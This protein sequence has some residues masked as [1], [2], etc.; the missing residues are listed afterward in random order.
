MVGVAMGRRSGYRF[1]KDL[2]RSPKGMVDNG[3]GKGV[4]YGSFGILPPTQR[5]TQ[6]TEEL[7][8]DAVR[9]VFHNVPGA[10][11]PAE[12]AFSVPDRK[13]YGGAENLAQTLHN[14]LPVRGAKVRDS[15]RWSQYTEQALAQTADTEVYFGQHNGPIWGNAR[16]RQFI[17][18]QRD[19]CKYTHDQ[20]VRLANAGLTPREIADTVKLPKT[21]ESIFGVRGYCGDLR[22]NGK[23]VHQLHLGAH[24]GNPANLNPLPPQEAAKRWCCRT[25]VSRSCSGSRTRCCTTKRPP[26]PPMPTPR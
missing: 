24:D 25:R 13:A 3:L 19:L 26:P 9:I 15:L 20:T 16:I 12:L 23:A 14:L 21:L 8:V 22:H 17:T 4:A 10:E 2:E 1:G 5:V 18:K 7:M 11:A 6:P